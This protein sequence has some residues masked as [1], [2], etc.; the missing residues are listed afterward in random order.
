[1]LNGD[2]SFMRR[3]AGSYVEATRI[4]KTPFAAAVLAPGKMRKID[5]NDLHVS[6]AH[7]HAD[8]LRETAR[9]MGIMVLESWFSVPGV[10]RRRGRG[11]RC[12]GRP[13]AAPPSLWSDLSWIC[14]GRSLRLQAVP[15][16]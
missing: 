15:S 7:S 11:W 4:V 10:L 5:I 12:R 9:H 8:T 3:D 6:L 13:S 1:M 16:T 2:L 14:Q